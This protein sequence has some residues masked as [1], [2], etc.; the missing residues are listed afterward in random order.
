MR[1]TLPY[2]TPRDPVVHAPS[3]HDR[4]PAA[5]H[6]RIEDHHLTIAH[7]VHE[8]L[9]ASERA[10][11]TATESSATPR[12]SEVL[13]ILLTELYAVRR[14]FEALLRELPADHRREHLRAIAMLSRA[15][16][17]AWRD[18][19]EAQV[20]LEAG[21][22]VSVRIRLAR[23]FAAIGRAEQMHY[24]LRSARQPAE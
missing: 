12:L 23:L 7:L 1:T 11:G 13:E 14:E 17:E 18:V 3:S 20:A 5:R 10:I 4:S 2:R 22:L 9:A 15:H 16:D 6:E 8:T 21:S 19:H 24:Y